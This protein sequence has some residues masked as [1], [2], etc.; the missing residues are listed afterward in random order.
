MPQLDWDAGFAAY[1]LGHWADAAAASGKAGAERRRRRDSLRA[2]AAFWAA[3]AH[4]QSGDPQKVVSLLT[5][6]AKEEPTFYGL[7]A[8]RML[9]MDTHTGFSDAGAATRPISP[10]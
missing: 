10:P 9:G 2:Q 3:R 7:I 8:E 4:M 5:A 6:A 1:R